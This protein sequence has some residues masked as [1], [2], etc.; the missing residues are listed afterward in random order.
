MSNPNLEA[1]F[2]EVQKRYGSIEN[3]FSEGLGIDGEQ[4]RNLKNLYLGN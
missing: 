4:Q 3:Y 1:S 2:D